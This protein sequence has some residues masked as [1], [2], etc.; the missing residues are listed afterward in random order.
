MHHDPLI[1][2]DSATPALYQD[3]MRYPAQMTR[4][5]WSTFWH[6]SGTVAGYC[7]LTRISPILTTLLQDDG[8][9]PG[10]FHVGCQDDTTDP[11]TDEPST[12][13]SSTVSPD[14][15]HP[16]NNT[17]GTCQCDKQLFIGEDCSKV[18]W[19]NYPIQGEPTVQWFQ[20]LRL[21]VAFVDTSD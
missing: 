9:C 4:L 17:L 5:Y 21:Y 15:C 7:T 18:T 13:V 6:T 8:R 16:A 10:A 12:T 20:I 3:M 1:L 19:M 11:P 14:T 2:P